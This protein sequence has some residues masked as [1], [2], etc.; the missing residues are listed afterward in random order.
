MAYA[1]G[2]GQSD[3]REQK[4]GTPS[5]A[6]GLTTNSLSNTGGG[7]PS[8]TNSQGLEKR[9][10]SS[11]AP[12][13]SNS[14][15]KS[16]DDF[17]RSNT[18]NASAIIDRNQNVDQSGIT[19][20][21]TTD[22]QNQAN[23]QIGDIGKKTTDYN[24]A[25]T[26][27]TQ[28]YVPTIDNAQ[29]QGAVKGDEASTAN[30]Q[31]I[32]NL[33]P[34]EVG[35]FDAGTY[36][37]I[38]ANEYLQN[39]D[40]SSV[41]M[42]RGNQNYTSGMA[43]LDNLMFGKSGGFQQAG[44]KVNDLQGQ[45]LGAYNKVTDAK[46]GAQ[47]T[48]QGQR[49]K[50]VQDAINGVRTGL[51]DQEQAILS[52]AA[53][54]YQQA[55][56]GLGAQVEAQKAPLRAQVTKQFEDQIA[57]IQKRIAADPVQAAAGQDVIAQLKQAMANP[58]QYINVDTPTYKQ[59]DFYNEDDAGGLNKIHQLLGIGGPVASAGRVA[60]PTA[61]TRDDDLKNILYGI[62]TTGNEK[63]SA[64]V[65]A[66]QEAKAEALR[67]QKLADDAKRTEQIQASNAA[68]GGSNNGPQGQDI[69]TDQIDLSGGIKSVVGALGDAGSWLGKGLRRSIF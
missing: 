50:L 15:S 23:Q 7:A 8:A 10:G 9:V 29:I 67:Q 65:K 11:Q 41:L 58:D 20:K 37:P 54:R 68:A 40:I 1:L 49:N 66:D 56:Q 32:L 24:T 44:A 64:A 60:A 69:G 2:I 39:G 51:T 47:A 46:T 6:S 63:M 61:R 17:T 55:Q 22:A 3:R 26:A 28:Q 59:E 14:A 48:A 57:D 13:V 34:G 38:K 42:N 36:D 53:G 4:N 43:A 19:N 30:V 5:Q 25:Q 52:G 31:K 18:A 16:A 45:V 33:Q 27:A 21:I 35:K 12:G 62:N